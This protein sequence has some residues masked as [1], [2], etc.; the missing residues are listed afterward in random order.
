MAEE[1]KHDLI[2][3]RI[4]II[5]AI[6]GGVCAAVIGIYNINKSF[7]SK[8]EPVAAAPVAVQESQ[9]KRGAK[10]E[11]ALEEVGASWIQSLKKSASDKNSASS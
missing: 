3:K 5:V 11:S 10:I 4:Q 1:T 8:P 7:F 9:P 2:L 6:I